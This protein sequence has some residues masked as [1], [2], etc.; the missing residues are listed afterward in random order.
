MEARKAVRV[1]IRWMIRRDME[2]VMDIERMCFE[3]P[4]TE[5][6]MIRTLRQKNCIAMVAEIGDRIVGFFVYELHA[7][8]LHLMSIAVLP[9]MQRKGIGR[10]MIAKLSAE[11]RSRIALEVREGNTDAQLFFRSMGFRAVNV[12]RDFYDD[13]AEDAYLFQYRYQPLAGT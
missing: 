11:R 2:E 13:T 10:A 6:D 7:K 3:F 1:H 5:D 12:L 9:S 4:W 8:S